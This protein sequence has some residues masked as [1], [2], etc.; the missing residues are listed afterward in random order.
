MAVAVLFSI[1]WWGSTQIGLIGV[2]T[3]PPTDPPG[4][5]SYVPGHVLDSGPQLVMVFFGAAGCGWS[6]QPELP[7][8]VEGIKN[9]LASVARENGLSFKTVGVALDWSPRRGMEYLSGFG[10]F[11]ELVAGYSLGNSAALQLFWTEGMGQLSTPLILVYERVFITPKDP[12]GAQVYRESEIQ[13][14]HF[15]AGLSSIISW[16]GQ[17]TPLPSSFHRRHQLET[18]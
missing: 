5:A 10:L 8:A 16:V 11:D 1:G 4:E 9:R 7:S 6:N 14:V 12:S 17:G 2:F 18:Q 13:Q 15:V 3:R